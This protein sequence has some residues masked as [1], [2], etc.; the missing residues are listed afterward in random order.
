MNAISLVFRTF[1]SFYT[2]A[3]ASRHNLKLNFHSFTENGAH[4]HYF[5]EHLQFM[6]G[7]RV[8]NTRYGYQ[9]W[10]IFACTKTIRDHCSPCVLAFIGV[11]IALFTLNAQTTLQINGTSV[12]MAELLSNTW[13]EGERGTEMLYFITAVFFFALLSVLSKGS[14]S[15]F[16]D[17]EL[18]YAFSVVE[19]K[20]LSKN[21]IE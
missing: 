19:K 20:N 16:H 3:I 18:R 14:Q 7:T 8:E 17:A 5:M 11:D 10:T 15:D 1:K 21:Y 9:Y 2:F 13:R 4:T 12:I 6:V